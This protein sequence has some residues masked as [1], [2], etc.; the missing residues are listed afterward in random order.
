MHSINVIYDQDSSPMSEVTLYK[1]IIKVTVS[2]NI[3]N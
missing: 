3:W 2:M 1:G